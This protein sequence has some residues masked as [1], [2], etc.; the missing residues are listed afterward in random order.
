MIELVIIF[1]VKIIL[2]YHYI[3][4]FCGERLLEIREIGL[5]EYWDLWYPP[6][7]R[8]CLGNMKKDNIK[9]STSKKPPSLSLKNLTGAFIILFVGIGLSLCAFIYELISASKLISGSRDE[10]PRVKKNQNISNEGVATDDKLNSEL[11]DFRAHAL[12]SSVRP[13]QFDSNLSEESVRPVEETNMNPTPRESNSTAESVHPVEEIQMNPTP[14]E[15]NLPA[16]SG[17]CRTFVP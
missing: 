17:E 14:R 3:M 6:V 4:H 13:P 16:E 7:S 8:N 15:S 1:I 9:S 12:K 2:S 10:I 11:R 5:N